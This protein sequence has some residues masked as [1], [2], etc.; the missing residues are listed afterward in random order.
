MTP[1]VCAEKLRE[2][3]LLKKIEVISNKTMEKQAKAEARRQKLIDDKIKKAIDRRV[4]FYSGKEKKEP[5]S[6][7]MVEKPSIEEFAKSEISAISLEDKQMM[8]EEQ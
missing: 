8:L 2:T 4:Q 7:V 3:V 5:E 6:P 1:K